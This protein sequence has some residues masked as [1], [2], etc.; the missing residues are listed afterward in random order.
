MLL[1]KKTA[2]LQAYL[3]QIKTS[4]QQ[5]GFVPTMGAL[6]KG[7]LALLKTAIQDSDITIC[8]IFVNPT[9]FNEP[10]DLEAYPRT[11]G[12]DIEQLEKVGCDILFMPT[13]E[14]VYPPETKTQVSINFQGLDEVMEGKFRPGH[15]QGVAQVV[16]RLLDLTKAD[17]LFMGQKDYQQT[18]IIGHMLD[19]LALPTQLIVCPTLRETDGLALS[20]RNVRLSPNGRAIAPQLYQCLKTVKE[21]LATHPIEEAVQAGK[22]IL[23]AHPIELEYLEVAHPKTLQAIQ[24]REQQAVIC[25]AAWIDGVRLIDNV[26]LD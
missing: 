3:Q 4:H 25:L 26:L 7:H 24:D 20:S 8:S 18:C 6:H 10:S 17:K 19:T 2:A 15:F 21:H 5:I 1:F 12:K 14:E 23:A 22:E 16:K 11:P 13:V 9:Q